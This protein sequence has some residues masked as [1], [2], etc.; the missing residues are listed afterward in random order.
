VVHVDGSSTNKRSSA[1]T[2][3]TSSEGK[4]FQYTVKMDFITINNEV[5]YEAVLAGL[6]IAWVMGV[7]NVEVRSDSQVVVGQ[8]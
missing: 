8:I 3:L 6:A 1:G 2:T 4:E 7:T 5:E